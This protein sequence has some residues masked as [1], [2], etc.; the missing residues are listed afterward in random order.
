MNVSVV[1]EQLNDSAFRAT[2]FAPVPLVA[3]AATREQAVDRIRVMIRDKLSH[4]EVIQVDVPGKEELRDPWIAMIGA[5]MAG[6]R[7]TI[8]Q[9]RNSGDSQIECQASKI[10]PARS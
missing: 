9:S 10:A 6:R 3:E 7:W 5:T 2:A 8:V 1:L 4:V